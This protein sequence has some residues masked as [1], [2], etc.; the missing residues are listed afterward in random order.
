MSTINEDEF[1]GMPEAAHRVTTKVRGT[2]KVDYVEGDE[3]PEVGDSFR[4][5]RT[6]KVVGVNYADDPTRSADRVT[7]IVKVEEWEG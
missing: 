3:L 6:G 1:D 5:Q 7:V 4:V 2:V